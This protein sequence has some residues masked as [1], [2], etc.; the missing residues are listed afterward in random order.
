MGI[1]ALSEE[2]GVVLEGTGGSSSRP[3]GGCGDLNEVIRSLAREAGL[4]EEA[5]L[6][7]MKCGEDCRKKF[8]QA[9]G[10]FKGTLGDGSSSCEKMFTECCK[11]VKDPKALCAYI[12]RRSGQI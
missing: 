11:G 7:S 2:L 3:C 4:R 5:L 8:L 6:E 10:S 12:G 1:K 9:D